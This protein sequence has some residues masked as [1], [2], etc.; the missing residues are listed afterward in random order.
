MA[1]WG[2]PFRYKIP[3]LHHL[4]SWTDVWRFI[5][6]VAGSY[7][8]IW[9][10][11]ELV[12]GEHADVSAVVKCE[13]AQLEERVSVKDIWTWRKRGVEGIRVRSPRLGGGAVIFQSACVISDV[14]ISRY[15]SGV[16][17]RIRTQTPLAAAV[18][19]HLRLRYQKEITLFICGSCFISLLQ[20]LQR[21]A[22]TTLIVYVHNHLLA[23]NRLSCTSVTHTGHTH[24]KF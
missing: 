4:S 1:Q 23:C 24:Q 8:S 2:R 7:F 22:A 19:F 17:H 3:S 6:S 11:D 14:P 12:K 15:I 5:K 16:A 18:W 21:E 13:R 20:I 9:Q 10:D